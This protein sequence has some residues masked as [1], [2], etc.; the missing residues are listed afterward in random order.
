MLKGM[1]ITTRQ[2]YLV[3]RFGRNLEAG[4]LAWGRAHSDTWAA[5]RN[6]HNPGEDL[7]PSKNI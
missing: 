6:L 4:Q 1:H 7:G 3:Q 5:D 2:S